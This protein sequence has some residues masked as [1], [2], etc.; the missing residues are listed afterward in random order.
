MVG[1]GC[2]IG[3]CQSNGVGALYETG[4]NSGSDLQSNEA[5]G[6]YGEARMLVVGVSPIVQRVHAATELI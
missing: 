1:G 5:D 4:N 3:G 2:V 6:F